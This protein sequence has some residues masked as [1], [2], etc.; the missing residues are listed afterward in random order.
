MNRFALFTVNRD[1]LR[2]LEPAD[3]PAAEAG[4]DCS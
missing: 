4:Q 3:I 1:T 2:K